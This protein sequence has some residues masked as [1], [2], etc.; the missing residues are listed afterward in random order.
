M[1]RRRLPARFALGAVLTGLLFAVA[2]LFAVG[3]RTRPNRAGTSGNPMHHSRPHA[4]AVSGPKA[5]DGREGPSGL[6]RHDVYRGFGHMVRFAQG[7]ATAVQFTVP[8]GGAYRLEG[9]VTLQATGSVDESFTCTAQAANSRFT[10]QPARDR[11]R[12]V[13]GG[14]L[15]RLELTPSALA[16]QVAK[17]GAIRV[18]CTTDSGEN[19]AVLVGGQL[20]ATRV[21]N[22][23]VA[24]RPAPELR[25]A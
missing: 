22:R 11:M 10:T 21:G 16:P 20:E 17:G 12:A 18:Y 19:P 25:P 5:A 2:L 8:Q 6:G 15:T 7:A 4:A 13:P 3:D 23:R 24:R 14:G 1:S 9:W